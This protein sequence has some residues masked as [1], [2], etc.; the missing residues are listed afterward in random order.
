MAAEEQ[1]Q[2]HPFLTSTHTIDEYKELQHKREFSAREHVQWLM[3]TVA[4]TTDGYI[5]KY[6]RGHGYYLKEVNAD[7][8]IKRV[9]N[10]NITVTHE[11]KTTVG[12]TSTTKRTLKQYK[13]Y[14][15]ITSEDHPALA[16]YDCLEMFTRDPHRLSRYV[17]PMGPANDE[18]AAQVIDFMRSRVIN[19]RA[20]DEEISS[21]AYRLRYPSSSIEKCF[22]H[23][24]LHGNS[25][26]APLD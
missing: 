6:R 21:H 3:E 7:A 9:L 13:A 18:W 26:A 10:F 2:Q 19:P 22:V 16:T 20:F 5:F 4:Q 25:A 14:A 11:T 8:L 17:P 24:C 15:F 12:N 1:Q 23:H